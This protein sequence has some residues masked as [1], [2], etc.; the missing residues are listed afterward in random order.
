VKG[1]LRVEGFEGPVSVDGVQHLFHRP[2]PLESWPAGVS[3][4]FLDG[5]AEGA[6]AQDVG[7][8]LRGVLEPA[9]AAQVGL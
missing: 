3:E 9:G 6:T 8:W 4:P 1:L 2:R 7:R 5:I